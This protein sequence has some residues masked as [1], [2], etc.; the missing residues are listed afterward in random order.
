MHFCTCNA[1]IA[2]SMFSLQYT[3]RVEY[4]CF[5]PCTPSSN[6]THLS[7]FVIN[8]SKQEDQLEVHLQT[9][10]L[11]G[12]PRAE[13][14]RNLTNIDVGTR[15]LTNW[16][17]STSPIYTEWQRRNHHLVSKCDNV[18]KMALILWLKVKSVLKSL[19]K[20]GMILCRSNWFFLIVHVAKN[21]YNGIYIDSIFYTCPGKILSSL[22][23]ES[24]MARLTNQ[25]LNVCNSW[26]SFKR[27]I[28]SH[29][30]TRWFYM[31]SQIL[32]HA[33]R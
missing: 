4:V 29:G 2:G 27:C 6:C 15:S 17:R 16:L 31:M 11:L 32:G 8:G 26:I 7:I 22:N 3:R 23:L 20:G 24:S 19:I 21:A 10:R 12:W 1:R 9:K 25:A 5:W 18:I 30:M 28:L 14:L 33:V 13:W